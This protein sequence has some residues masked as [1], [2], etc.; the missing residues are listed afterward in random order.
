VVSR[1]C[2]SSK[3]VDVLSTTASRAVSSLDARDIIELEAR[4][5]TEPDARRIIAGPSAPRHLM[6]A[7]APAY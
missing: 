5:I 6:S 3:R 1:W 2:I 7:R 4:H